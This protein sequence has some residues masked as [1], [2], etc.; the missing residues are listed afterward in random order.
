MVYAVILAPFVPLAAGA[1]S[2]CGRVGRLTAAVEACLGGALLA[3]VTLTELLAAGIHYGH[4]VSRWNP[5]MRP[6]IFGR[7]NLIHI[8][9]VR[10]TV[11]GLVAGCKFVSK[12][13]GQGKDVL[14]VGTKRQARTIIKEAAL[15]CGMP[16]V[17]DRWLGGALTNFDVI[18]SR[19]RRL[20]ELEALDAT[21]QL[22][23]FSKKEGSRMRREMHQI[24]RN[25]EGLRQMKRLPGLLFVI[26]PRREKIAVA[27]AQRL[28]IPTVCLLDTDCDPDLADIAIPGN[29]DA[30]RSIDIVANRIADAVIQGKE[31]RGAPVQPM[32]QAAPSEGATPTTQATAE[33][34]AE[35]APAPAKPEAPAE[36]AAEAKEDKGDV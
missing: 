2:P 27:E 33:P 4:R 5:K 32:A 34:P 35:L 12:V 10:E 31:L 29:D 17:Y 7:R 30:M 18:R 14:F 24:H 1:V 23:R 11:R 13:V 15:R 22:E 28:G 16:Y 25:L 3:L 8:V 36:E 26:D 9:D 19:L 20:E 6:F 21:G